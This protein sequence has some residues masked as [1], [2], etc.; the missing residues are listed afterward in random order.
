GR[1]PRFGMAS[2]IEYIALGVVLGPHLLGVIQSSTLSGFEP[3]LFMALGWLATVMGIGH[4]VYQGA[5]VRWPVAVA[6]TVQALFTLVGTLVLIF[7]LSGVAGL[8]G[9]SAQMVALACGVVAAG[10]A[11]QAVDWATRGTS[12]SRSLSRLV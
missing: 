2:G 7:F 3:L 5:P 10:S 4:G 1:G 12:S 11:Y 9:S 8:E 6:G